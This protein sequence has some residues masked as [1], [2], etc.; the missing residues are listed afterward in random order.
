MADKSLTDFLGAWAEHVKSEIDTLSDV[1]IRYARQKYLEKE[2]KILQLFSSPVSYK[3]SNDSIFC[4]GKY[5][6]TLTRP[7]SYQLGISITS[8][9]TGAS[10]ANYPTAFSLGSTAYTYSTQTLYKLAEDIGILV[11]RP[12]YI[13]SPWP[14]TY[15]W[16]IIRIDENTG[17]VKDTSFPVIDQYTGYTFY[18]PILYKCLTNTRRFEVF[19]EGLKDTSTSTVETTEARN[20]EV[21]ETSVSKNNTLNLS[22][23]TNGSIKYGYLA[24]A[25][26]TGYFYSINYQ[27]EGSDIVIST[28]ASTNLELFPYYTYYNS[29]GASRTYACFLPSGSTSSSS[30]TSWFSGHMLGIYYVTGKGYY[31]ITFNPGTY[32]YSRYWPLN[33]DCIVIYKFSPPATFTRTDLT[34]VD[35]IDSIL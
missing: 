16:R 5:K 3:L 30:V 26:N 4:N 19:L 23:S 27:I 2:D 9:D 33:K 32:K 25:H 35:I 12:E 24:Y 22:Y 28:G 14:R 21:Y 31:A 29:S 10:V 6:V 1:N 34:I 15:E 17:V 20:Y 7:S 8:V 11:L 18:E 13:K